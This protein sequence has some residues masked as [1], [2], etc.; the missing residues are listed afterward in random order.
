MDK[1]KF[2]NWARSGKNFPLGSF[3]VAGK[4]FQSNIEKFEM[5]SKQTGNMVPCKK[6]KIINVE[7]GW[8]G[9]V[10]TVVGKKEDTT[11]KRWEALEDCGILQAKE[12][13][14]SKQAAEIAGIDRKSILKAIERDEKLPLGH[15]E[16]KF[17]E[18]ELQKFGD[19]WMI[20]KQSVVR[21]WE[22]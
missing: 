8:E 15:L 19:S 10:I 2:L 12:W 13:L 20:D 5:L 11:S 6:C 3:T 22:K 14:T 4:E 21:I 7:E 17:M 18:N 1:E 9:S 16:K